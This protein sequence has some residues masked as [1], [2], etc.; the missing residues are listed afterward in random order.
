MNRCCFFGAGSFRNAA[1]RL[2]APGRWFQYGM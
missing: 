1:I 2:G